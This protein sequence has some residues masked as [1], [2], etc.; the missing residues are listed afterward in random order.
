MDEELESLC[1]NCGNKLV[2]NEHYICE[3]CL[4]E[5]ENES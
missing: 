5:E 1:E 4:R 3:D 2:G